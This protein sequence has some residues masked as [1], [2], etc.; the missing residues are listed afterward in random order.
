MGRNVFQN[1]YKLKRY[2]KKDF[3]SIIDRW[4]NLNIEVKNCDVDHRSWNLTAR[5]NCGSPVTK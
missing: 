1:V 2:S 4:K 3:H 5:S